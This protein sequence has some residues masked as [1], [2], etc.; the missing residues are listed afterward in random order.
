M[1][2]T[3]NNN[4]ELELNWNIYKESV[5]FGERGIN[6]INHNEVIAGDKFLVNPQSTF[7]IE[8]KK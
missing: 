5:S 2:V 8:F 3:N 1:V 6:I 4:K 7:I